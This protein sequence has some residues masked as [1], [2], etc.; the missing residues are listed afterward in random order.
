[1]VRRLSAQKIE[2]ARRTDRPTRRVPQPGPGFCRVGLPGV[3]DRGLA[4]PG[5]CLRYCG[6]TPDDRPT[7][8]LCCRPTGHPAVASLMQ[9]Q[10]RQAS[11]ID[12]LE[13]RAAEHP[14]TT[15]FVF[16]PE[17]GEEHRHLTYGELRD[18]TRAVAASLTKRFARGERA[19]LLFP[20][21]LEFIVAFFG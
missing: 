14:S 19:I 12:V 6:G 2:A 13:Q 4:W 15:A 9:I 20:P 11:L 1:M 16:V 7:R 5:A 18:R 10:A 17:R 3:G 8:E 21:G